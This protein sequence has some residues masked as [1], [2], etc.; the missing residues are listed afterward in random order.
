MLEVVQPY[1]PKDEPPALVL[2][3]SDSVQNKRTAVGKKKYYKIKVMLSW[4]IKVF[5]WKIVMIQQY[6][7]RQISNMCKP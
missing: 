2:R 7:T 6:P 1:R 3:K 4:R 5:K